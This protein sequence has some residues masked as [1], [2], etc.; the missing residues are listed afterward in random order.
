L[1]YQQS[2][3]TFVPNII[4][5]LIIAGCSLQ[6]QE[7]SKISTRKTFPVLFAV[8]GYGSADSN[9]SKEELIRKITLDT[10]NTFILSDLKIAL[11]SIFRIKVKA[12]TVKGWD[13]VAASDSV[14]FITD[15]NHLLPEMRVLSV[16]NIDF[17]SDAENYPLSIS[18][19]KA[20]QKKDSITSMII[21]GVTAIT[22]GAG[23]VAD[24][25]GID[26]L[27]NNLVPYFEKADYVHIS[28]EVSFC[29]NCQYTTGM[30]FCTK[31]EHFKAL[32]DLHCNIVELTGN[33][34]LDY[35]DAAYRETL[36]WYS[37]HNI[38]TFGGGDNPEEANT[39]LVISLKD[40][41]RIG[42]IGF[43]EYC[44]NGEC[45][46][47]PGE[48]GANRYDS[49]KAAAV[50]SKMKN[51]LKCNFVIASVQF[52]ECDFSSPHYSQKKICDQLLK[53]G[54]DM[55]YGSQAHQAQEV[56][57]INH[58]PIFYGLGNLLF[59]QIHRIAVRQA[60]FL[61][62]YFY[63]GK[64]IQAQPV[65]TFMQ[66]NRQQHIANAE[67]AKEIRK[68]IFKKELIY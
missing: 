37:D 18:K 68:V 27:T 42:F 61:K 35:G 8:T 9:I 43:N 29:K 16:H 63:K 54:A 39:P 21:S 24:L 3:K 51:E 50:I 14:L 62:L 32:L 1:Q 38:K 20:K 19:E 31:E 28:N 65:F 34:N 53:M 11:D 4:L 15:I 59:D 26:F 22:R 64:L 57:F 55:V 7:K 67:E 56:A 58:K 2:L 6:G 5:I 12:L 41:T 30:M 33:H 66:L 49:V 40:S 10:V 60:F 45:A 52:G 13:E 25:N 17:F 23:S 48:C 44:P 47:Y 36:K 46:D